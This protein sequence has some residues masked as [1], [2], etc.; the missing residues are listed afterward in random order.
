MNE[1]VKKAM[2]MDEFNNDLPD[3]EAGGQQNF[4]KF[5]MEQERYQR[6]HLAI[7]LQIL[8][9]LITVLKLLREMRIC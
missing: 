4:R 7:S 6:N 3:V 5:G 8:I 9:G 1:V 2:E